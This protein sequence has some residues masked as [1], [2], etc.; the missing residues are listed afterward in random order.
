MVVITVVRDVVELNV[1]SSFGPEGSVE[2]V[3]ESDVFAS[4]GKEGS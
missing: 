3:D 4:V 1:V 2:N